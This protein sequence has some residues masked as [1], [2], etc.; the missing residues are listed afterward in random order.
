MFTKDTNFENV[1]LIVNKNEAILKNNAI[2]KL[3]DG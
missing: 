3:P 2:I 1:Y